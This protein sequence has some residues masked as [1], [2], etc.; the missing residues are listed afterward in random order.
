MWVLLVLL[1]VLLWVLLYRRL[2]EA[3]AQPSL[4]QSGPCSLEFPRIGVH[5][6]SLLHVLHGLGRSIGRPLWRRRARRA[7]PPPPLARENASDI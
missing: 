3:A 2:G 4:S 1:W 6:L 7:S 5:L